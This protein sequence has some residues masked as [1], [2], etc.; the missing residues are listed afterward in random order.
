M[1]K[2]SFKLFFGILFMFLLFV[3]VVGCDKTPKEINVLGDWSSTSDVYA[4]KENTGEKLSFTYDK[5][6]EPDATLE[7][8][9]IKQNL[10]KYQKLVITVQGNGS[11]ALRLV[12]KNIDEP[13]EVRINVTGNVGTYEWNLLDQEDYLKKVEKLVICAAPGKEGSKGEINI[14]ALKFDKDPADDFIIQDGFDNIPS[15]VNEYNGTDQEFHFNAKWADYADET[16]T[17]TYE[18]NVTK[19]AFDKPAGL[20]WSCMFTNV[21][22]NFADFNYMV[23]KAKG[24]SG[25]K[26]LAK[27]ATGYENFVFF[28]G[29]EQEVVVDFSAMTAAEKNSIQEIII[30]GHAGASG[31]GQFE[32]IDAFMVGE[33]D[34]EPP[35]KDKNVYNGVD[36][37]F[38]VDIWYDNGDN[39]YDISKSG[40]D[41]VIDYTK[42]HDGHHWSC[43]VALL[44]G[45]LSSFLKLEIEVTGIENKTGKF[46]LEGDGVAKEVD[47]T[48]TGAKQT[49][50]IDL[51]VL[52][53]AQLKKINKVVLFA[54]PG[55]IGSGQITLHKVVF[56]TLDYQLT[57]GWVSND[58]GVYAFETQTAGSV[59]VTYNKG[60]KEWA[61]MKHELEDAPAV[62]N[63]L[64]LVLK[65][66]AGKSVMLKPNDSSALEQTVTFTGE[67]QEVVIT[68]EAFTLMM[69]FAEPGTKDASGEFSIVSAK[70][71]YVRPPVDTDVEVDVNKDWVDNDGGIYTFTEADG[72]VTVDFSKG[73]GKEWA[74]IKTV[75]EADL[76]NHNTIILKVKGTVGQQLLVKPNDNGAFEKTI[77]FTGEEQEVV[78]TLTE[79]PKMILMFADPFNGALTGSFEIISA[80]VV[81]VPADYDLTEGWISNDAGVYVFTSQEDDSVKVSYN[82]GDKEWAFMK[83]ELEGA[84]EGL[85]TLTLVLKGV[86]GKSVML[87]PNDN[88]AL[89][90]TVTFTG[91]EQEI[92]IAAET[93][94]L[95]MMFAEAGTKDVSGE[96][97]IVSAVLSY[98]PSKTVDP[99]VEVDVN[100]NWVDNEG[101]IYTFTEADGKVTVD[102]S[103][104]AGKEWAFIKTVFEADL[105][106]HNTIILKVKGTVGQQL[107]V[108][109]NDNG[110][111]EKTIDFTGEEQEVVFTLTEAPKMILMFADPFNGALTGSFEII[112][113][114]VVYVPADYDLTEGWISNDAG[115]Y[116]FTSQEDDSVKVSYNKG[117]KEWAFMKH[118]LEGAAEGLNT[119]TLVL[120][121]VAGK[122]VML[123]PNDNSALEQTV[124][125]TGEEQEIV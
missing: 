41:I 29:S 50:I 86:A 32:I 87:K 9:L 110:A 113:A 88:S 49:V 67:E 101:G 98:E 25:Q 70:L 95:M 2:R 116:V 100:N 63:T 15:N 55:G 80:K 71:S 97:Y 78:F 26:F 61:F 108:K 24:T 114:K 120:K 5:G 105:S 89:E 8:S 51:T 14:T 12:G 33:Y 22:G 121:G 72:K 82:K 123:K 56:G 35:V 18:G 52:S 66:E 57:A 115:V 16:Y 91:E 79:A 46:K 75:F 93:F 77:D 23:V 102:F 125:F 31:A 40:T 17:I 74:F 111:F 44:E 122:S 62:L 60:D 117:D 103:K 42:T 30:F 84:A 85:N 10:S 43:A 90:Q 118:E 59:K 81:Y 83:H 106:N 124:T 11:M 69:M 119:L 37:E 96:F 6:N 34:Y 1:T 27:V 45:D 19:V 38:G 65:G 107:L 76:S 20:E 68:A 7:S 64:T 54:A 4:I 92:V 94:T 3:V 36:S 109:P 104:G 39:V 112:S 53:A 21:K 58:E 73:A 28:D 47:V 13:K 48:F 99:S